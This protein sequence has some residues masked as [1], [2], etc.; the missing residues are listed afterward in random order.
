MDPDCSHG[1]DVPAMKR[2]V[3]TRPSIAVLQ[4][5]T[6]PLFLDG[7]APLHVTLKNGLSGVREEPRVRGRLRQPCPHLNGRILFV[8]WAYSG[9]RTVGTRSVPA[10]T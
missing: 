7:A 3:N 5:L 2:R 4:W 8:G 10:R 1:P 9:E 6:R